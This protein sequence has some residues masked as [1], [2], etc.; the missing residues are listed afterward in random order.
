MNE[1]GEVNVTARVKKGTEKCPYFADVTIVGFGKILGCP[2]W[3]KD[4]KFRVGLPQRQG[5]TA[6]FDLLQLEDGLRDAL[7]VAVI[8]ACVKA[9][10][11]N[12]PVAG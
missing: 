1:S 7:D 12:V 11:P 10:T 2:V 5:K 8:A 3:K 4:G 6:S 9:E